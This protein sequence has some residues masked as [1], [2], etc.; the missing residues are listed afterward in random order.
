[1]Y[2]HILCAYMTSIASGHF[3]AISPVLLL[4]PLYIISVLQGWNSNE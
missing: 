2:N 1:M 4:E 3:I